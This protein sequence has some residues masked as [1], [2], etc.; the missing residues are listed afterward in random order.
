MLPR[1]IALPEGAPRLP[2]LLIRLGRAIDTLFVSVFLS[3]LTA[4]EHARQK[5]TGD[6]PVF[7]MP[8][9]DG[10]PWPSCMF[11]QYWPR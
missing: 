4:E 10:T 2:V 8:P 3:S 7:N 5:A 11:D 6:A 1:P 9:R